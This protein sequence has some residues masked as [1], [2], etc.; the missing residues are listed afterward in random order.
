MPQGSRVDTKTCRGWSFG[1][2]Q[3]VVALLSASRG[4][5]GN[6]HRPFPHAAQLL[7]GHWPFADVRW[8]A[9]VTTTRAGKCRMSVNVALLWF[10]R[11]LDWEHS[12]RITGVGRQNLIANPVS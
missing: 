6:D 2:G 12:V 8:S 9:A 4:R 11:D 3:V 1:K 10:S 5:H 7:E